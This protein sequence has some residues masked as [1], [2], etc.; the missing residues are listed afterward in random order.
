VRYY[1]GM[2]NTYT[3]DTHFEDFVQGQLSTGRYGEPRDVLQDALRLLEERERRL[4]A[5]DAAVERSHSDILAGRT[6][7]IEDVTKRLRTKY[8]GMTKARGAL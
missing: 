1:F 4:S 2:A 7:S 8:S 6:K 5:L 3:L